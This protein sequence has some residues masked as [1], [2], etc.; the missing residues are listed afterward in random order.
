MKVE[1]GK[2]E[3]ERV[4]SGLGCYN[5]SAMMEGGMNSKAN[6]RGFTL[7]EMLVVIAVIGVL[8]GIMFRVGS[9]VH[10]RLARAKDYE[11][12]EYVKAC[13]EGYYE[14][15]GNYPPCS[16]TEWEETGGSAGWDSALTEERWNRIIEGVRETDPDFEMEDPGL[17]YYLFA[18]EPN[19]PWAEPLSHLTTSTSTRTNSVS[20]GGASWDYSNRVY[21]VRSQSGG[22][23]E[24]SSDPPYQSYEVTVAGGGGAGEIGAGEL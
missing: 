23:I 10:E 12:L 13:I 17:Y 4:I 18:E 16:G 7:V 20:Y 24:Y 15:N 2:A 9:M 6:R 1:T 11:T 21:N 8:A 14:L 22:S 5:R 19:P 3:M